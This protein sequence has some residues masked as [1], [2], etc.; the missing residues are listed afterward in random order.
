MTVLTAVLTHLDDELVRG[1]VDYL[2]ELAPES[3]FVACF[4]GPRAQFD[5][6]TVEDVLFI[7]EPSL[8][9]GHFERSNTGLLTTVY[10]R[11]VR[12][13][14]EIEFV[15]FIEFDHLILRSDFEQQLVALAN[16]TGAGLLGK[17]ASP[18]NDTNWPHF[19]RYRDDERVNRFLTSISRR[20]D[21]ALRL[22]CLGSGMLLRRE[23]LAAFSS[24]DDPPEVYVEM[25]VPTVVHH[26]GFDVVDV[27]GHSDLYAAV[28]WRPEYGVEE[29]VAA[30]RA[31]RTFVHPFK[32]LEALDLIRGA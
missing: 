6:L 29:A 2:R 14:P 7:D 1:Q 32:R 15:Y 21:V 12:D 28:S 26:L 8:Q 17:F 20:D 25:F 11:R 23:A 3:R 30:K 24:I 9:G 16:R 5:R 10:E 13:V 27:D 22:G 31:G 19:L 4:G 18:R